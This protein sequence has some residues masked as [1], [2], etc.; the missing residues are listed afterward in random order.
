M[1]NIE[2]HYQT[3]GRILAYLVNK[4]LARVEFDASD[5]M[6]IMTERQRDE[7]E[8]LSTFSDCLHWMNDE[9]LI[10]VANI[11]EYDGGYNFIGVQLTSRGIALIKSDPNDKEIG[12]SIEKRVTDSGGSDLG[13]SVY[14]RIGEFIGSALGG[15]TKSLAGG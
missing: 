3:I 8:V 11:S 7:E 12:S 2:Y 14:T 4:G 1:S 9:G 13:S 5:A 6:E 10:R 15:F